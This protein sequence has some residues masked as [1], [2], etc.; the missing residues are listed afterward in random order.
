MFTI[1]STQEKFTAKNSYKDTIKFLIE[2]SVSSV[3]PSRQERHDSSKVQLWRKDYSE[4]ASTWQLEYQN[5]DVLKFLS[6]YIL[7]LKLEL[8]PREYK[9][10]TSVIQEI[11]IKAAVGTVPK[12]NSLDNLRLSAVQI[13]QDRLV[14]LL[15]EEDEDEYGI[16]KPTPYAFDKAWNLV[17]AASRLMGNSF[18]SASVSTDDE[19]GI[20]LT[21]TR[22]ES[23]AEVRLICPSQ[24]N[25][26]TYLYY[27]KGKEY[28]VV[29]DVSALNLASWL[30]WMNKV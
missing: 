6:D 19:G 22:L 4:I 12:T 3:L 30:Q 29:N 16:L 17:L 28:G 18:N 26:Q 20:R 2:D 27:E 7:Q 15:Q 14:A 25:K 13:T 23:E 24:F 21:W 5:A 11:Q 1:V 9:E 8:Q 10:N